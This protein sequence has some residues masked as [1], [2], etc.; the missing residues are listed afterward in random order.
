MSNGTKYPSKVEAAFKLIEDGFVYKNEVLNQDSA[1]AKKLKRYCA[2]LSFYFMQADERFRTFDALRPK[3]KDVDVIES[4]DIRMTIYGW[5]YLDTVV[6]ISNL[7]DKPTGKNEPASV[8]YLAAKLPAWA[9]HLNVESVPTLPDNLSNDTKLESLMD[10]RSKTIIH[11]EPK[12]FFQVLADL[13]RGPD[14]F[15]YLLDEISRPYLES[16]YETFFVDP[17]SLQSTGSKDIE[18]LT[19]LGLK[20]G[21]D[22]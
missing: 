16:V 5:A 10:L 2:F 9:R 6:H 21:S 14:F 3:L 17:P 12:S 20:I 22:A 1:V 11:V 15:S 19:K 7:F 8:M 4:S 18:S 13:D